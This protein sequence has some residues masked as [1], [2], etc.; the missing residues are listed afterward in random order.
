MFSFRGDAHKVYLQVKEKGVS[1]AEFLN[2][3]KE[4]KEFYESID[5]KTLTLIYYRM[6]KEKSASGIIPLFVSSIPWLLFL[7]ATQLQKFL[8]HE[9][10]KLWAIFGFIYLLILVISVLLHF[11]E[12]AW[13]AFHLAIIQD[14]LKEREKAPTPN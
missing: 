11:R 1:Q 9:G 12:K 10:S 6:L 8:F 14:I 3:I 2:E 4:V 7:F 5:S 13:A